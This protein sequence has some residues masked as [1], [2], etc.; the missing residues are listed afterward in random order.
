MNSSPGNR[1]HVRPR[2][3]FLGSRRPRNWL[4]SCEAEK[5]RL[6]TPK[7]WSSAAT[8]VRGSPTDVRSITLRPPIAGAIIELARRRTRRKRC[9]RAS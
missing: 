4:P 2:P 6:Q 8:L 1:L 9:R 7:I 3:L 5:T